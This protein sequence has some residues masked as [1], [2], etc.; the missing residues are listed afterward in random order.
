MIHDKIF[1]INLLIMP[2]GDFDIILGM[3]WLS[4]HGVILDC[5]KK[6]FT[7]QNESGDKIEVNARIISTIQANKLIHQG[8]AFFLAYVINSNSVISQCNKIW[9][10]C[11]F[12]DVFPE[13][14]SGL[15][16]NNEVEFTIELYLGIAPKSIPLYCMSPMELK[17]LKVQLQD[18]LDHRFLR[19]STSPWRAPVLFVK[20][21]DNLFDQLKGASVFSKID[22][23]SGFYQLKVKENDVPKTTF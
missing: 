6:K 16:P 2:F 1:S 22:L 23:R 21:K 14:L 17:K 8:C 4:E 7:I 18:L 3:D 11:E 20:K 5:C 9:T 12:P 13:E 15:P 10:V 19:P